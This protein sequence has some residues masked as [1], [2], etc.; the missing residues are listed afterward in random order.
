MQHADGHVQVGRVSADNDQ[1]F[2]RVDGSARSGRGT[3][4]RH[5]NVTLRLRSDLIDLDSGLA[6][7][8][9]WDRFVSPSTP[10]EPA[11]QAQTLLT[12]TDELVRDPKLLDCST[13]TGR[14]DGR[15]PRR[16]HTGARAGTSLLSVGSR[17]GT[18][19]A[20][21][22]LVFE[23]NGPDVVDGN[24]HGIGDSRDTQDSLQIE[25]GWY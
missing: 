3:R 21:P 23:Q 16:T 18:A 2:A 17:A 6:D 22:L 14:N 10:L 5:S 9:R 25:S 24:V 4:V 11:L 15:L 7:D 13:G 8:W 20:R 12:T 1:S 19:A